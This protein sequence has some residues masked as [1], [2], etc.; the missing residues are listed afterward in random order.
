M[1]NELITPDQMAKD[2]IET[3][4][5]TVLKA[6]DL[7]YPQ[8]SPNEQDAF[9]KYSA[10]NRAELISKMEVAIA[11]QFGLRMFYGK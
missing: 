10:S 7:L 9:Q 11:N 4:Q 1:A 8:G 2:V 3:I 5:G 6:C